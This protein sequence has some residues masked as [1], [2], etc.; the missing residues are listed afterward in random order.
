MVCVCVCV[1]ARACVCVRLT[2]PVVYATET[3]MISIREKAKQTCLF[4]Y[5]SAKTQN[6]KHHDT[7]LMVFG[8]CNIIGGVGGGGGGGGEGVECTTPMCDE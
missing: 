3:K 6:I 2:S 8:I 1:C 5:L 7:C 4:L